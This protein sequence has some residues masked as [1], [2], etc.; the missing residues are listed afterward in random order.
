MPALRFPV[1]RRASLGFSCVPGEVEQEAVYTD[2]RRVKCYND[3]FEVKVGTLEV[4]D[5]LP[6]AP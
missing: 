1:F 4:V 3:R 5:F 6:S 2:Y